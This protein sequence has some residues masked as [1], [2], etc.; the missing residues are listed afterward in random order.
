MKLK[1]E[2]VPHKY[3]IGQEITLPGD[4]IRSPHY[5]NQFAYNQTGTIE[6]RGWYNK[7]ISVKDKK[8]FGEDGI[9]FH[10][11]FKLVHVPIYFVKGRWHREGTKNYGITTL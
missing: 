3:A 1:Y 11:S 9:S 2:K 4:R 8:V 6:R 10:W 7:P 5:K